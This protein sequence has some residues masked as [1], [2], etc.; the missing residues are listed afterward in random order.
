MYHV[1]DFNVLEISSMADIEI[2]LT[3][4]N[5]THD[6]EQFR[7]KWKEI[8]KGSDMTIF[9][10]YD[11]NILLV[12]EEK[13]RKFSSYFSKIV[14]LSIYNSDCF[15]GLVPL[16]VQKHSNK[17]KWFGRKRGIY[18]LGHASW[19]D[20]LNII[21]S[22]DFASEHFNYIMNFIKQK[23]N[24][25]TLYVTDIREETRFY[26]YLLRENAAN[27]HTRVAVQVEKR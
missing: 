18:I 17:T 11:W 7:E 2:N 1:Q 19:S 4:I 20:Y 23:Y 27:Y 5:N 25:Y 3:N 26:E 24:G 10:S 22:D 13:K 8:E 15:V 12:E 14:V 16:I 6:L 9:Q 21:Y